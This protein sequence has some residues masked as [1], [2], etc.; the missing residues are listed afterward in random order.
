MKKILIIFF[1]VFSFFKGICQELFPYAESASNIP[2]NVLGMRF[3]FEGYK[4]IP[5]Q[6]QRNWGALRAMYGITGKTT[7]MVTAAGSNHHLAK[8]PANLQN[9]FANHHQRVY[10]PNPYLLEGIN[11][12]LKQRVIS[13]DGFQKHLRV[14][15]FGQACKSFVPHDESE[16]FL[17]GDNSGYGGGAII[18]GLYKRFAI[19]FTYAYAHPLLYKDKAQQIT[20]QAGD[21]NNYDISLGYR[22][23]PSKYSTYN[24]LNINLYVEF[25]NRSYGAAEMTVRDALYDFSYLKNFDQNVYYSLMDGKYSEIRPSIQLILNSNNRIDIG[26]AYPFYGRS[27]THFYP[28]FFFNIQKYFYFSKKKKN[29]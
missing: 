28:L 7:L 29:I 2:K 5:S 26:C 22:L 10:K 17:M 23:F 9:Y 16:P 4:E 6:R 1:L 13:I 3:L 24:D 19:S 25:E 20:F 27:Y 12:Y 14:A 11:I 15:L 18:T 8:F 21:A